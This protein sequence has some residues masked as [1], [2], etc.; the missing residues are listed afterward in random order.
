MNGTPRISADAIE[1]IAESLRKS[2]TVDVRLYEQSAYIFQPKDNEHCI[3]YGQYPYCKRYLFLV[4]S[5]KE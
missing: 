2:G 3:A 4:I 1:K 5:P